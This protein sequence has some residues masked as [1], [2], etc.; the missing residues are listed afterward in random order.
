MMAQS[1]AQVKSHGFLKLGQQN[2]NEDLGTITEYRGNDISPKHL[3]LLYVELTR[4]VIE[5]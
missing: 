1:N 5:N 4:R 2:V 3:F